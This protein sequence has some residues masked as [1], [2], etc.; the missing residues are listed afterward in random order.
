MTGN[1]KHLVYMKKDNCDD[2]TVK[3]LV[4]YLKNA[5]SL[6]F[7]RYVTNQYFKNMIHRTL[8]FL[9]FQYLKTNIYKHAHELEK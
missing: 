7:S 3:L 1:N 8:H 5:A 6:L 4:Y 2:K 9:K